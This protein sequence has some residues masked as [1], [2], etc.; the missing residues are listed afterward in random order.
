MLTAVFGCERLHTYVYGTRFTIES[1]HTTLEMIILDNRAAVPQRLQRMLLRIQQYDVQ[2][3]YR[4][5]KEMAIADTMSRQPRSD[6]KTIELDMQ[7]SHVQFPSHKLDDL[8]RETRNDSEL[9]KLFKV[10]DLIVSATYTHYCGHSGHIVLKGNRIVMPASFHAENLVKLHES[11][12][13]IEE[14]RLRA[15]SCVFWAQS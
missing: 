4:S 5:G 13:G 14:M 1:N 8:R 3:R 6:N 11:H 12:Q 7:I 9:Q 15:H 10:A 2:I